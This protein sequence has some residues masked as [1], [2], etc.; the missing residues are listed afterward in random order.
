MPAN[1]S[2]KVAKQIGYQGDKKVA[3]EIIYEHVSKD[4]I[5]KVIGPPGFGVVLNA[6]KCFHYGSRCRKK[7]RLLLE[8]QYVSKF[9]PLGIGEMKLK[10]MLKKEDLKTISDPLGIIR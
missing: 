1:I 7:P 6:S 3:D 9:N 8:I 2:A 5:K 4:H 10:N